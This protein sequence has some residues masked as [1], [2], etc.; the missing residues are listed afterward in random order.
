[1]VLTTRIQGI[2][3]LKD[4]ASTGLLPHLGGPL[5]AGAGG[6]LNGREGPLL[7]GIEQERGRKTV[8][9]EQSALVL[10]Q[11]HS[12]VYIYLVVRQLDQFVGAQHDPRGVVSQHRGE[13]VGLVG[14]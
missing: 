3:G 11:L 9:R 10:H 4:I 7:V 2:L 14:I 8:V 12:L 1:M 5:L 13:L 6:R